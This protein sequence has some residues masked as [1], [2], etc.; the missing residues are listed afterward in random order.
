M[1]RPSASASPQ[2]SQRPTSYPPHP[3]KFEQFNCFECGFRLSTFCGSGFLSGFRLS[4]FCGLGFL[5]GFRLSAYPPESLQGAY[6][7]PLSVCLHYS[8]E[9]RPLHYGNTEYT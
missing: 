2:K 7:E 5:S 9:N 8:L 1:T 4:T 3:V 6:I